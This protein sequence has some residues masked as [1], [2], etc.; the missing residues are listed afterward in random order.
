MT[1]TSTF[2]V[3][4]VPSGSKVPSCKHAQQ[5]GLRRQ[6]QLGHLVQE[7]GAAVGRLEAALAALDRAGE[8]AAL[9]TEQLRLDQGLAT[10]P[11]S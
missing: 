5:L 10:A 11:R 2:T 8:G 6:R 3:V 4:L 9:V 7:Q 1:R